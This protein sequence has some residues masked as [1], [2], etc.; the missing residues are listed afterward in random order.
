MHTEKEFRQ[1][2]EDFRACRAVL[3]ALGDENRLHMLYGMM[4][5]AEPAPDSITSG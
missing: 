3:A 5:A 2:A 1:L 4:T